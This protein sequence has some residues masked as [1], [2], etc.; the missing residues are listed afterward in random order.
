MGALTVLS[1]PEFDV[2]ARFKSRLLEKGH[3]PAFGIVGKHLKVTI[4]L[5]RRD[6]ETRRSLIDD[7]RTTNGVRSSRR[8]VDVGRQYNQRSLFLLALVA[9]FA[10]GDR[11][12]NWTTAAISKPMSATACQLS[13]RLHQH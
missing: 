5:K 2:Q 6:Q 8:S 11:G 9:P 7:D 12:L 3:G 10:A 4:L 13:R 1:I